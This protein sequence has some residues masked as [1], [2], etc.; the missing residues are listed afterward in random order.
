MHLSFFGGRHLGRE[1]GK[2]LTNRS[3]TGISAFL[4]LFLLGALACLAGGESGRPATFV[5]P[6]LLHNEEDFQRMRR[7]L[8][9]EPRKSGWERLVRNRHASLDYK[10]RP[11]EIVYRGRDRKATNTENYALL[12]NDAA[13]AYQCALRWRVS[14][15]DRYAEKGIEILNA[16]SSTLKEISGSSDQALARGI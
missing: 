2:F 7:N 13:A 14:R 5:H 1:R 8:D 10:P 9:R 11:V 12:F 6:G 4:A 16:W 15:D 3:P